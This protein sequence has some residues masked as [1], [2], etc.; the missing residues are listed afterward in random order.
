[1]FSITCSSATMSSKRPREETTEQNSYI[2]RRQYQP[3]PV[4]VGADHIW[5]KCNENIRNPNSTLHPKRS[6]E[7]RQ[8][9]PCPVHGG[10]GHIWADCNENIRNTHSTLHLHPLIQQH[11]DDPCLVHVNAVHRWADCNENIRNVNSTLHPRPSS[12]GGWGVP[13]INSVTRAEPQGKFFDGS[14]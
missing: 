2:R 4:H 12:G 14:L 10:T 5:A 8:V 3:C 6:I 1:M 13:Y 11:Q 7:Q 9:D